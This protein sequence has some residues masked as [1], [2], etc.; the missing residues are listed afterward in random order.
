M[1]NV[2]FI[3]VGIGA[4]LLGM[5]FVAGILKDIIGGTNR[6]PVYPVPQPQEGGRDTILILLFLGAVV[7]FFS[8]K[9]GMSFGRV[10]P[11]KENMEEKLQQQ[12]NEGEKNLDTSFLKAEIPDYQLPPANETNTH[13][14]ILEGVVSPQRIN[15]KRTNNVE[16]YIEVSVVKN[17]NV[18]PGLHYDYSILLGSEE[19]VHTAIGDDG[20][21]RILLGPFNSDEIHSKKDRF[22]GNILTN[23]TYQFLN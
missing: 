15:A 4:F 17:E 7:Y 20:L 11:H 21:Y 12:S 19:F 22:N 18:T 5:L 10:D 2:Y 13:G 16:Y 23:P 1:E 3:Y 6:Q 14:T 9:A 8:T